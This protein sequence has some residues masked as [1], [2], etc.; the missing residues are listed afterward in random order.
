MTSRALTC[1]MQRRLFLTKF[2]NKKK[3]TSCRQRFT[4]RNKSAESEGVQDVGLLITRTLL[5]TG[6]E[7][8]VLR[9]AHTVF[10]VQQQQRGSAR[11]IWVV[12]VAL[13]PLWELLSWLSADRSGNLSDSQLIVTAWRPRRGPSSLSHCF[14][15][16]VSGKPNWSNKC[17]RRAWWVDVKNRWSGGRWT[18]VI[19]VMKTHHGSGQ[20]KLS[21]FFPLV[22]TLKLH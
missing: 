10:L 5:K 13:L 8:F 7:R 22:S 18:D 4:L 19:V 11:N 12:S 21:T 1:S 6:S 16:S 20:F 9:W 2:R 14:H 3:K 17:P 15:T